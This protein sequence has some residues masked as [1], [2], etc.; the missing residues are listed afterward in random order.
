MPAWPFAGRVTQRFALASDGL[1]VDLEI[2]ADEPMPAVIGW[3][4]WF[5]RPVTLE[6]STRTPVRARRRR[7]ADRVDDSSPDPRPWD[8]CFVDLAAPPRLTWPDGLALEVTSDADHWVIYDE[9][10]SGICVEPQTGPPDA[11]NLSVSPIAEPDAP[12]HAWMAW[13]WTSSAG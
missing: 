2:V 10:P 3:H 5:R 11:V 7:P 8:D 4:P 6:A 12:L 13:S 1:R 9:A